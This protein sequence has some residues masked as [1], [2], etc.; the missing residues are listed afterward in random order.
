MEHPEVLSQ[1]YS[2]KSF[3][4][5]GEKVNTISDHLPVYK[6]PVSD[7]EFGSYLSG[8]IEGDGYINKKTIN[9]TICFSHLDA[10][11][12]YYIKKRIG[13][14]IVDKVKGKNALLYRAN[15]EGSIVIARLINGKLRTADKINNFICLLELINK[16]IA[17]PIIP[18]RKDTSLLTDSYWLAGFSDADG[19]FQV[20]TIKRKENKFG[21]EIRVCFQ[22][23][24]KKIFILE[25]IREVFGGS[26]GYR[27]SKDTFYYSSV[28]FGSAKKVINYFDHFNLLSSKHI[29]FLKWRKV[30]RLIQKKKHLTENGINLIL[31]IKSTMNSLSKDINEL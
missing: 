11:L 9:I 26:I 21:E 28:S 17:T 31:K 23:D 7:K 16:R 3:L 14:G 2:I 25:Q 22:I 24:Q 4:C 18:Q 13:Y 15:L 29:N 27:K 6:K 12:A 1:F 5:E 10:S 30:Y 19:S 8:L 20:K